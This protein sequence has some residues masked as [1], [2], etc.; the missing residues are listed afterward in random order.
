MSEPR[1]HHYIPVFYLKQWAGEDRRICEY[2][3]VKPGKIV[4][5]RTFP[6]GTG[7]M[8]DLYRVEGV[9]NA[10]SQAVEREFM[11]MVDTQASH[12]LHKL[13]RGD[14]SSWNSVERSAWTR[15]ILSLRFRN[16]DA[17][18]T[19]KQQMIAVWEAALENM[20]VTYD[21]VRY[22]SDPPTFEQFLVSKSYQTGSGPPVF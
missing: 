11:R 17:V 2:R 6:D 10:V 16:P 12:A 21:T 8:R 4:A 14:S 3:R 13:M 5:H 1:K 15:F 7:Y 9:P 19:I 18:S 20:R 22:A